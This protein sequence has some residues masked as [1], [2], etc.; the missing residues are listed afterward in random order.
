MEAS[1]EPG[2][3]C[4]C[5]D[6]HRAIEVIGKRWSGP[7]LQSMLSGLTRFG[8]I[9]NNVPGLSDRLLSERLKS[10]EELGVVER[11]TATR[12]IHYHLTDVGRELKP[13]FGAIETWASKLSSVAP[14][15]DG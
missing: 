14:L 8:D 9:R 4:Y 13:V 7:I 6:F 3:E 11:C 2:G 1:E 5:A 12:D 10:F 15:T